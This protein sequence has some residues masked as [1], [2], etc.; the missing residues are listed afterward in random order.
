MISMLWSGCARKQIVIIPSD[1]AVVRLKAA[2]AYTP[3]TDGWYMTDSL[4]LRY[5]RAVADKIAEST[6]TK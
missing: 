3:A 2:T 6:A 4:Y 1:D 5:R